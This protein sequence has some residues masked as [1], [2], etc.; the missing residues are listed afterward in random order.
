MFLIYTLIYSLIN[1]FYYV[2]ELLKNPMNLKR[3]KAFNIYPF[4]KMKAIIIFLLMVFP[5]ALNSHGQND[6]NHEDTELL[7]SKIYEPAYINAEGHSFLGENK[8]YECNFSY[9]GKLYTNQY[10]KY[11]IFKQRLI[12]FNKNDKN[13]PGFLELNTYYIDSL[14][15]DL[16][17]KNY[18]YK[19]FVEFDDILPEDIAVFRVIYDGKVKFLSSDSKSLQELG[20]EGKRDLFIQNTDYYMIRENELHKIKN[21]RDIINLTSDKKQKI[22]QYIKDNNL[23]IKLSNISDIIILIEFYEELTNI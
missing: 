15:F 17:G 6:Y 22:K 8:F 16:E 19:P 10:V 11:D 9:K 13:L 23:K 4:Y 20:Y 5:W 1:N 3:A 7:Y 18:L 2:W 14:R 12:L 21:R